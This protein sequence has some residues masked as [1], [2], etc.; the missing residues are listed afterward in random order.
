MVFSEPETI[1]T[2]KS[3]LSNKVIFENIDAHYKFD[4]QLG[5]GAYSTVFRA[6]SREGDMVAIK[7][8]DRALISTSCV[9]KE[10]S[11]LSILNHK[12]IV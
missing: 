10:I 9:L 11:S 6:Y 1:K 5:V 3:D 7:K 2:L 4:A 8:I 12:N